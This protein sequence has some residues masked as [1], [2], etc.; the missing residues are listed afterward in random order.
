MAKVHPGSKIRDSTAEVGSE[1]GNYMMRRYDILVVGA[2]L[3]GSVIAYEATKRGKSVLV[4]DRRDHIG[5]NCY[6]KSVEG[7]NVHL[8]GAHI[9]R[10]S[11]QRI[12]DYMSQ[13]C[14]FNNFVNSPIANYNGEI[15]NLPFT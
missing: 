2:G 1:K 8:Y 3:F 7:I 6:T 15:Y 11:D 4:L 9:F 14:R 10:T 5:G 13:F 12:W